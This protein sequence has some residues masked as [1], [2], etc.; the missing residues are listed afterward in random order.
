MCL[1]HCPKEKE[2]QYKIRKIIK[3]KIKIVSVLTSHNSSRLKRLFLLFKCP[4]STISRKLL[5]KTTTLR[6]NLILI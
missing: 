2:N 1:L 5:R 3:I 4:T 6:L